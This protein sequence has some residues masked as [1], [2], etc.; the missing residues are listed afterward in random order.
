MNTA[1]TAATE[2]H[3]APGA[4]QMLRTRVLL[5]GAVELP[6]FEERQRRGHLQ[7]TPSGAG[8]RI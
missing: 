5:S 1:S 4:R 6:S 3:L 7:T 8:A 2:I